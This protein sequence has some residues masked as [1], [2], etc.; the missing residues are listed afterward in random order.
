MFD[1]SLAAAAALVLAATPVGA[2][3]AS[4]K[5]QIP[6]KFTPAI[7][8]PRF[9][10]LGGCLQHKNDFILTD[11]VVAGQGENAKP[12]P[13]PA[14]T[15]K[16]EGLSSARLSLF[17]GK[18]VEVSGVYQPPAPAAKGG[19]EGVARFEATNVNP[20]EGTCPVAN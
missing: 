2:Q 7:M 17:V 12:Q 4:Q 14:T 18:R 20:A 19:A 8:Q 11:A 5:P 10:V 13:A 1:R 3:T 16:V 6:E 9:V 15:Y